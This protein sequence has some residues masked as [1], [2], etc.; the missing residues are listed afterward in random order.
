MSAINC[1]RYILY[2]HEWLLRCIGAGIIIYNSIISRHYIEFRTISHLGCHR[3]GQSSLIQERAS[4]TGC[5]QTLFTDVRPHKTQVPV[6]QR[7]S[8]SGCRLAAIWLSWHHHIQPYC[9]SDVALTCQPRGRKSAVYEVLW[10]LYLL[11]G[12]S[13]LTLTS[14]GDPGREARNL[15][16]TPGRTGFAGARSECQLQYWIEIHQPFCP[17][18]PPYPLNTDTFHEARQ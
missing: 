7:F 11:A 17:H 16:C 14:T 13:F 5:I 10:I 1:F 8:N 2:N 3:D 9:G 15:Q 18:S 6:D 4:R 12:F